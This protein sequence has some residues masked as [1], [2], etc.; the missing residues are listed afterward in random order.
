MIPQNYVP[1]H[2]HSM[3]SNG[4]TNIDSITDFHSYVD[5]AKE[6][7]MKAFAFSE[8]G[9][10]FAWLKKKEYIESCGM[11]YIHAIEAYLTEDNNN[12]PH[13]YSAIDIL[14]SSNSKKNIRV[15]YYDSWKSEDG[16]IL[17]KNVSNDN[18]VWIDPKSI[19]DEGLKK[20][21]DNY[22]ILLIAK[23]YDGVKELNTLISKSSCRKDFHYYYVPRIS[24]EELYSTSDNI[25]VTTACLGGVLHKGASTAKEKFLSFL[26][27]NKHRCFLEIQHHNVAEQIEY[28][29]MLYE[30]HQQIGIPLIAGTDSHVLNAEQLDGRYVLQRA[31]DVY[32]ANEDKW[33]LCFKSIDE[34][35]G[36]Y[37]KQ[38]SLPMD[39][40]Y[41]AIN[42]TN[43]MADMVEEFKID[44][45]PK[46]P[47]LYNNS[48]EVF[49]QKINEGIIDR[50]ITKLPNY[51]EYVDRIHYEYDVYEHNDA[52]DFMLLEE[53]YKS[54]MRKKGIKY[55]YSRGSA[56]GSIIA[57]LLRITEIDSVKYN[58]NFERFMNKERVSL[59][60]IDTDWYSED[61]KV[62]KDYLHNK[63]GLYCCDIVTFNTIALKGAI[64]DVCRG[65]WQIN[66]DSLEIPSGLKRR[67][68]EWKKKTKGT[69]E[70][71]PKNIEDE[72]KHLYKQSSTYKD[73]PY[74]YLQFSENVISLAESDEE[75]TR[76]KYQTIFKYVDLVN[77]VVVSVGNHPAGCVVSP[78]PVDEWFGTFTTSTNEYPISM[79]NMKEIDSLNFV[80]LDI[81][82]LD[83]IGLIYKTCDLANIPFATPDNIPPDDIN[84]W[85][86]IK[87]DTTMI[88]QW[89]SASATAYLKQLFSDDTIRKIREKNPNA[90]YMDLFSIGNGAIRPAGES[91]RD[92]LAQGIY[93][94]NGNK[95]L[96][97]FL[98]YTLGYLVYQE[99]II[100]FL[101]SFSGYTM[102]EADIVRRGFAKKTGTEQFIPDIKSGFVKVME[103]KYNVPHDESE[104]IIVSFIKVIEDASDYL[105][106]KNHADPYS[107]I[108]YICGYLR[109]YYPLEFITTALNIFEDKEDKSLAILQYAKNQNIKIT[110]I[111]FRHSVAK[112][113][114]DKN[115]NTIF[116]GLSSIKYMND[117]IAN[118][119]YELG[120][121][122]YDDFISLLYDIKNKTSVNSKQLN[123][124]IELDFF[125]EFGDMNKLKKQRDVFEKYW[126]K[127][128]LSKAAIDKMQIPPEI[129]MPYIHKETAK[130]YTDVD[131]RSFVKSLGNYASYKRAT[132]SEKILA[133]IKHLGY[134]TIVDDCYSGIAAVLDIDTK[135][136]PKLKMYSLKNGTTLD[137]KIDKRT[138]NKAKLQTGDLV[139]VKGTKRKLK[140][141]RVADGVWE[142]IPGT[143]ELWITSYTKIDNL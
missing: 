89:E 120:S 24:F 88:F 70:P 140:S 99:Q 60:D 36:A 100:E 66:M 8:H 111:R 47:K 110:P 56:S 46:Y 90:S 135:Y 74:D 16:K 55:G 126:D 123:I 25:I 17:V 117:D 112:Y 52:I 14:N 48:K 61:R 63:N 21:K 93:Q 31:K 109:Y 108:G 49:K 124:L 68:N 142:S 18:I 115:S 6:Y 78:F 141:K 118:E 102:G 105:F 53:D 76:K 106:S 104:K 132:L 15:Q 81:L 92:K 45:S 29:Q 137:C 79:L 22:H 44:Y 37:K 91:Y 131:M 59:A 40:V 12:K 113:N 38:K 69:D 119:L 57:Y 54:A 2:I 139:R 87:E 1:Y 39:V 80:K 136:S 42:N 77:G 10:L 127:K 9:S 86:S 134:I 122:H 32:F 128:Q 41:E 107:W 133:Q 50:G 5:K 95:A 4:I 94:D 62:V 96:N 58:L 101:H 11:K 85:N 67:I 3:L 71:M 72:L 121:N 143:S 129:Y 13:L 65:L 26:T 27:K 125:Q 103:E 114:F 116:K 73:V 33:D 82:G 28:N 34:L 75:A 51:Q 23:N 35:I 83:N 30:L 20:E 7:G 84:V 19:K 130:K 138:F 43:V 98:S 64:K 97:D